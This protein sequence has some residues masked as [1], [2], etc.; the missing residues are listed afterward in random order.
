MSSIQV[1]YLQQKATLIAVANK[2]KIPYGILAGVYGAETDFG[3]NVATSSANAVGPFQFIPS[4]AASYNYPLTNS[5]TPQQFAQQTDAAGRYLSDLYHQHG[6][7]WDAALQA[8]SVG[9]YGLAH[10]DAMAQS[11]SSGTGAYSGGG[12]SPVAA[13]AGGSL[14]G[15][16]S[17]ASGAAG[18]ADAAAVNAATGAADAGAAGAGVDA[19]A[20]G[21]GGGLASGLSS[22]GK[23]VA[24]GAFLAALMDPHLWL[25]V[26]EVVGAIM[27][28]VFGL[29]ELAGAGQQVSPL[30]R[31]ASHL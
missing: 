18:A 6:G 26:V 3:N 27:L 12:V 9:G 28:L 13:L 16:L 23:T 4:T 11:L 15:I 5:P 1:N 24:T 19:A 8:Y 10:V 22:V 25:R 29:V 20:G 30:H 21:A 17:I 2:Y 7:N 31:V 14:A